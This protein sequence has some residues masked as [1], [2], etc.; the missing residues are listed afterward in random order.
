MDTDTQSLFNEQQTPENDTQEIET[1]QTETQ[2][3]NDKSKIKVEPT[4]TIDKKYSYQP[5][6]TFEWNGQKFDIKSLPPEAIK[7]FYKNHSNI[8]NWRKKLTQGQQELSQQRKT[9]ENVQGQISAINSFFDEHPDLIEIVK[10]YKEAI[11][12]GED[13]KA[14]LLKK[15]FNQ[16]LQKETKQE[17]NTNVRM[18]FETKSEYEQR[19]RSVEEKLQQKENEEKERKA[20]ELLK[21]KFPDL[22]EQEFEEYANKLSEKQEITLED[23]FEMIEKARRYEKMLQEK[24]S[25]DATLLGDKYTPNYVKSETKKSNEEENPDAIF[26]SIWDKVFKKK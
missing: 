8:A 14:Y 11:D 2:V 22:S 18:P 10:S 17:V 19:L 5:D 1:A 23:L 20:K 9:L 7:E 26:E 6:E 12:N 15:V 24:S 21:Q 4:K 3:G 25:Q 13:T 16:E